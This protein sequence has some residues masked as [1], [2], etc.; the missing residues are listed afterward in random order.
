MSICFLNL[1]KENDEINVVIDNCNNYHLNC[2]VP[3]R[4]SIE[5]SLIENKNNLI[6]YLKID[7]RKYLSYNY[8]YIN[9]DISKNFID[10]LHINNYLIDDNPYLLNSN[11]KVMFL[12]KIITKKNKYYLSMVY[13]T[14]EKYTIKVEFN[15]IKSN[16]HM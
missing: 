9:E 14:D 8:K 6:K 7:D 15:N 16:F 1:D 4:G 10:I 3:K 5:F 11:G 12:Q 13:N 2:K